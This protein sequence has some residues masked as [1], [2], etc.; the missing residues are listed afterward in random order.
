MISS[1]NLLF[2]DIIVK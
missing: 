1:Q 2:I